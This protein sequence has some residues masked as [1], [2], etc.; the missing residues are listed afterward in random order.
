MLGKDIA[1]TLRTLL[2]DLLNYGAAAQAYVGYNTDS[3]V[4]AFLTEEQKAWGTQED[5]AVDKEAF[6]LT[7][8]T[9]E[10]PTVQWKSGG[11]Y[12]QDRINMRFT[13]E[14]ADTT[15]LTIKIVAMGRTHTFTAEDLVPVE[16]AENQYYIYFDWLNASQMRENVLITAYQGEKAVSNTVQYSIEC[17]I[18]EKQNETE[19]PNL[20]ELVKAI[21]RYGDAAAAYL[22]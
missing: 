18:S 22:K 9:V 7:Y 5:A 8:A 14:T 11:L 6:N 2:V 1:P 16:N 20:A 21:I 10:N 13:L 15:D 12:L 4:N 17:Y 3:P 19:I